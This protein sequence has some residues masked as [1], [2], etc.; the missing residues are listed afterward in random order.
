MMAVGL[1][2]LGTCCRPRSGGVVVMEAVLRLGFRA[3]RA[4]L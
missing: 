3:L 4:L 2:P 1:L